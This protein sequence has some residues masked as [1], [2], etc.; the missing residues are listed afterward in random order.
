MRQTGIVH[1]LALLAF[2]SIATTHAQPAVS[3]E[4]ALRTLIADGMEAS[5]NAHHP[6]QAVTADKAV[7]DADFINIYGGWT[8]GRERF[9]ETIARLHAPAGLFHASTRRHAVEQLRFI[10]PDV[11]VAIV[12]AFDVREAGKPTGEETRAVIVYSKEA[13]HWKLTTFQNTI[14]RQSTTPAA[15]KK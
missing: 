3:D 2:G 11:A 5:W 4:Q 14:I 13:G 12:R 9:S 15:A 8:K 10:R 6:E 1:T 7:E